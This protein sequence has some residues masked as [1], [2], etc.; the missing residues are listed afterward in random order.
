ML[1]AIIGFITGFAVSLSGL[2]R[3]G[4]L[5][6]FAGTLGVIAFSLATL[7]RFGFLGG[8]YNSFGQI[9]FD[10]LGNHY[11]AVFVGIGLGVAYAL[12]EEGAFGPVF[13]WFSGRRG[14]SRLQTIARSE[15]K[16]APRAATLMGTATSNFN[17]QD[18]DL[19]AETLIR[20]TIFTLS[21]L[22]RQAVIAVENNLG[23]MNGQRIDVQR[24]IARSVSQRGGVAAIL[25]PVQRSSL[26]S[27]HESRRLFYTLCK[28]ARESQ[29][30]DRKAMKNMV[31][32]AKALGLTQTETEQGL[33]KNGLIA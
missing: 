13:D 16:P 2:I 4:K 21:G 3:E 25:K 26:K 18:L 19:R 10:V 20:L 6:A 7:G 29:S 24:L 27:H 33:Q 8:G 1:S 22:N 5:L 17:R 11:M 14:D 31:S 12:Y 30:Y 32:V 23:I 28:I 15:Q 9:A